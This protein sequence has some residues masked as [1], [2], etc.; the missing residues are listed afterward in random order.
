MPDMSKVGSSRS[1][2]TRSAWYLAG[3]WTVL[4]LL[5]LF[6]RSGQVHEINLDKARIEARSLYEL[7][8]AYR[9][10]ASSH[11]GLYVPL[12][13]QFQ[14]N[15]YLYVPDRDIITAGG[16]KLT[17]VNPAWMTRQVFDMFQASSALPIRNHLTSLKYLNPA[18]RPDAWEEKALSALEQGK[19]E[20]SEV[21][22]IGGQPYMRLLKPFLIEDSCLRCHEQQGYRIGDIR[23][24]MSLA[25]PLKDHLAAERDE[26]RMLGVTHSLFWMI[27]MASIVLFRS[28]IQAGQ[29][30]LAESESKYRLLFKNN[31]Y[32]TWVYDLETLAFLAVNDAAI[33]RYGYSREEFLSMT[34]K[35][36]R[37]PEEVP[38]LLKNVSLVGE[39]IDH[40]GVWRHLKK[41]GTMIFV[42]ITSHALLFDGRRAELVMVQDV[43]E[44]KRLEE[45]LHHSQKLEAVGLL[46]GGVAHD[47]NNILTAII[48]YS[49]LMKMRLRVDDPETHNLNEVIGAA[50]RGAA[51]TQSLLAFSRKQINNPRPLNLGRVI[52]GTGRLLRTLM[53]EDIK[54]DIRPSLE[55]LTVV[56]DSGQLEQVLMNLA[57][58]ARDSMPAGGQLL[59]ETKRVL[60]DDRFVAAHNYG[61]PGEY[62]LVSISDT[63]TGMD[64]RTAS[65]VFEPFFTTKEMGRGTGLGLSIVY[66]IV[67]QHEGYI[68]VYS[69]PGRGTTFKIYLPLAS[70]SG[71]EL[72]RINR[73]DDPRGGSE[74]ILVAEDD[75]SLR[76]LVQSVLTQFGYRVIEAVDGEDAVA[77]IRGHKH[78]IDLLLLDVIMPKKN[79]K[80]VHE[81]ALKMMPGVPTIFASGYTAD[82]LHQK[83]ILKEGLNFLSKPVSPNELLSRVR[84]V[85]DRNR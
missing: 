42:E 71:E 20:V 51:L 59:I 7:N 76:Q 77:K 28:N 61:K 48:G 44:R 68:N 16:K 40:A 50:E 25:I 64:A 67:K 3:G 30:R 23:G 43:S 10:W 54:M 31:P 58:N 65:R 12:T 55:P 15:P 78:E 84:E 57:T 53:G 32:P 13:D 38:A 11:G 26:K 83:G 41:D 17:L 18:N 24:G 72:A 34:I 21:Q 45:Q 36:I 5:S 56:A 60:L 52:E 47:F 80:D 1:T 75:A 35:D 33:E 8:L 19:S 62:A 27:G 70:L 14:P 79:G 66:G 73:I 85:L 81:E 74:T 29:K 63:G 37:P 2:T 39:G 9:A 4:I 6:W 49:S 22:T 82:I 69:E 46:A